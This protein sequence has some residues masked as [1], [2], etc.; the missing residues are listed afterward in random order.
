M[1]RHAKA[2]TLL[3]GL[4]VLTLALTPPATADLSFGAF[5]SNL[6]PYGSWLV[7]ASYGRVWQPGVYRPGWNPYYDGHWVYSDLGWTWGYRTM[8]GEGFPTITGHG[9]RTRRSAGSGCRGT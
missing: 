9:S 5:Y 2:V 8:G 6:S 3:L 1:M 7:S 4:A